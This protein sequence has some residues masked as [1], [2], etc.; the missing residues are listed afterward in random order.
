MNAQ[1]TSVFRLTPSGTLE[2]LGDSL[3]ERLETVL[4]VCEEADF[5]ACCFR[6]SANVQRPGNAVAHPFPESEKSGSNFSLL[7]GNP[8]FESVS[9]HLLPIAQGPGNRRF[10][11]FFGLF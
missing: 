2:P 1:K 6:L 7:C 5:E 3:T 10:S 8:G 4:I 9:S 11:G